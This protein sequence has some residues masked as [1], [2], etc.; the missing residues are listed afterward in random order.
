MTLAP[1]PLRA[2]STRAPTMA[3]RD[4]VV[5]VDLLARDAGRDR[6]LGERRGRGLGRAR[7]RDRPMIVD[8]EHRRHAPHAGDI[9]RLVEVAVRGRAVAAGADR[10]PRLA[11]Q[12]ERVGCADRVQ[13]LA[14]D[15]HSDREIV[16]RAREIAAALI[17]APIEQQ[18]GE[19]D[20][21]P[22]LGAGLAIGRQ[23]HVLRPHH[24]GEPDRTASCP[25]EEGRCRSAR[26]AA[27]RSPW[28]RSGASASCRGRARSGWPDPSPAR[29][30]AR[31]HVPRDRGT[32]CS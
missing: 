2:R 7:H 22:E 10:D 5:A 27:A 30:A 23:Q 29:A 6:L 15:R 4:H 20:A 31:P 19:A 8:H 12:L 16:A 32:G 14:G 17:A 28:R 13:A 9:D 1:S 3:D 25:R 21:A 18:L 26:C 11:P 24:A